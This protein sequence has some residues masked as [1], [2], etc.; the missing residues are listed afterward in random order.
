MTVNLNSVSFHRLDEIRRERNLPAMLYSGESKLF[1]F[2]YNPEEIKRDFSVNIAEVAIPG[3][4]NAIQFVG[5]SLWKLSLDDCLI[6]VAFLGYSYENA[7]KDIEQKL[8]G[9]PLTLIFGKR[10]EEDLYLTSV[11][12]SETGWNSGE[13]S[14]GRL[15]LSFIGGIK[16]VRNSSI[17]NNSYL[18]VPTDRERSQIVASSSEFV[19]NNPVEFRNGLDDLTYGTILN[20]NSTF[21]LQDYSELKVLL[22]GS[23]TLQPEFQPDTYNNRRLSRITKWK[24]TE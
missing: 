10:R 13:F 7:V 1:E 20:R 8:I 18:D 24:I 16:K 6:D 15:S 11:N 22:N 14:I 4:V 2:L 3:G 21:E 5:R 19:Y 17:S 23:Y 9:I 12:I